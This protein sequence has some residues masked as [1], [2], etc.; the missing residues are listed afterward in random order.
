MFT[1]CWIA[2]HRL[3]GRRLPFTSVVHAGEVPLELL[4]GPWALLTMSL[5]VLGDAFLVVIPGEVAVTALGALSAVHGTP[6]LWAVIGCAA[7]AAVLGDA[8]CYVL[9]RTV[10]TER[11]RWMRGRRVRSALAWAGGRIDSGLATV[12]FTARF[13]PFARLAVNLVA[14]AS[15]VSA[16]R[17]LGLVAVAGTGWAAYQAA[18]GA[19][20][21]TLVPGHPVIGVIVSVVV[22]IALGAVIDGIS[23][24]L[25]SPIDRPRRGAD[26]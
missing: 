9:G 22:A 24:R 10:G 19:V 11:W 16:P 8:S 14:G 23:R 6:P 26:G 3:S 15:R 5:L 7:V 4:T 21:G 2:G 17:Y 18:V 12:L 13:V 1:G 20:V 25:R